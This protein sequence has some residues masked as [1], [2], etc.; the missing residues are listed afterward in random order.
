M[1][2]IRHLS[3]ACRN[4]CVIFQGNT[5][6]YE[7]H[8]CNTLKNYILWLPPVAVV[9]VYQSRTDKRKINNTPYLY[10][11]HLFQCLERELLSCGNNAWKLIKALKLQIRTRM[12]LWNKGSSN[13]VWS[14][15]KNV[16]CVEAPQKQMNRSLN[17]LVFTHP[18]QPPVAIYDIS[19]LLGAQRITVILDDILD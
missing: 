18:C 6:N 12:K 8:T 10:K 5:C 16:N 17:L 14:W 2:A 15:Q 13:G 4:P 7:Y 3:T 19:A 9:Y 1:P 11:P